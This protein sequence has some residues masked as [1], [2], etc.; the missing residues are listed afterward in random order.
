MIWLIALVV[1]LQ[2]GFYWVL[3]PLTIVSTSFFE[4]RGVFVIALLVF[5]WVIS[6]RKGD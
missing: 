5:A 3:K 1:L 2:A 4:L 6:G